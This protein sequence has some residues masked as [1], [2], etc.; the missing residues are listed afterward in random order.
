MEPIRYESI[1]KIEDIPLQWISKFELYY[2]DL[3]GFPIVYVH[4]LM[5]DI[6]VFGF[7]V[8][9]NF[10]IHENSCDAN[11]LFLCNK[12][13]DNDTTLKEAVSDELKERFGSKDRIG[14]DDILEGCNGNEV[15]KEFFTDLWTYISATYG[16]TIPYGKFYDEIYSIIRFVSAWQPKTGRQSEMRMLYNFLSIFGE[17]INVEGKWQD[18]DFFLLP[19]YTDVKNKSFD[20]YPK[21]KILFSAME[22]IWNEQFTK[23]VGFDYRANGGIQTFENKVMRRAWP[24]FKDGFIEKISSVLYSENKISLDEKLA[25]ER[26]VDAFNRHAWRAAYFIS[27]IMTTYLKDYYSWDKEFF[28]AYYKDNLKTGRVGNSPKVIACFLQQG[29]KQKEFIPIDT[30]VK[31]FYEEVLAIESEVDFFNE[32]GNLGKIERVIWLASQANKTNILNF[33]DMLWCQRFGTTGNTELRGPNPIACYE[34][35][36]RS[37]CPSY[38]G[39]KNESVLVVDKANVEDGVLLG[40][41]QDM[42]DEN[43][44]TYVCITNS[45]VPKKV[46]KKKGGEWRLVDEFSGYLLKDNQLQTIDDVKTMEQL[47]EELPPFEFNVNENHLV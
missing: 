27:S 40:T 5:D 24:Q 13:I 17:R 42:A 8:S 47:I 46:Y 34:C 9:V 3:P 18:I 45:R 15:Y 6:R 32:F 41:T 14:L 39:V 26:L 36:L 30:W 35:K 25:L 21:F 44:C 33:F 29:F 37:T 1:I 11:V 28:I 31:T 7:P 10:D 20:E 4:I 16:E 38:S 43:D 19:N 2:P 23:T 22:K 12:D